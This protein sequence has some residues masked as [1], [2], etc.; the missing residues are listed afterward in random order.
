MH[1]GQ[2]V[3]ARP[4]RFGEVAGPGQPLREE[5][6]AHEVRPARI[7]CPAGLPF[8]DR[9]AIGAVIE[10][11]RARLW[12]Q[13]APDAGERL[14]HTMGPKSRPMSSPRLRA[15]PAGARLPHTGR[16][17]SNQDDRAATSAAE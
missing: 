12:P 5:E 17:V 15:P 1:Q 10:D 3:P 8:G 6:P 4:A 13:A 14:L 2:I 16:S 11:G 9:E 7:E